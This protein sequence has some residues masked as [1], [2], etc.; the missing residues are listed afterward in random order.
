MFKYFSIGVILGIL[1]V[2]VGLLIVWLAVSSWTSLSTHW[3]NTA[4]VLPSL[5]LIGGAM[6]AK[7]KLESHSGLR[8]LLALAAVPLCGFSNYMAFIITSR[9]WFADKIAPEHQSLFYQIANPEVMPA[10]ASGKSGSA[11]SW[12]MYLIVGLVAG[13]AVVWFMSRD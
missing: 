1:G 2:V 9:T 7:G 11:E 10:F 3:L 5:G 8:A 12:L 13:P 4:L 6:I